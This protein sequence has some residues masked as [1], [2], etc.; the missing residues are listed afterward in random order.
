MDGPGFQIIAGA[1]LPFITVTGFM[2]MRMAGCGLPVMN[3]LLPGLPGENMATTTAGLPLRRVY[4]SELRGIL[5]AHLYIAGLLFP[6]I[7]W[8]GRV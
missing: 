2:I 1:G 8:V 4:K 6:G 3:G 5:T 7:I